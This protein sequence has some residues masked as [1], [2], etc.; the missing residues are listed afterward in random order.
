M[1]TEKKPS[2]GIMGAGKIG[3]SVA[4]KLL[5][6]GYPVIGLAREPLD[7]L[8]A[9]G[10]RVASS[11]AELAAQSEIVVECLGS[12]SGFEAVV[13]G[14][15]G[16]LTQAKPGQIIIAL[17]SDSLQFKRDQAENLAR[18]GIGHLDATVSG[19][20]TKID[21]GKAII[22]IGGDEELVSQCQ[23]VL[24]SITPTWHHVGDHG[25]ATKLKFVNNTLSFV[26]NLAAAEALALSVKLGLDPNKVVELLKN[27][28]GSSPALILR[29]PKMAT[30]QYEPVTGDMHGALIV[31]D[32]ILALAHEQDADLP[33][34]TKAGE[35]Y[36]R[37]VAEGRGDQ[38]VAQ[39]F[40]LVL[41]HSTSVATS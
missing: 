16:F 2:I 19:G 3:L 32:A 21:E 15:D 39:L 38:D 26:H 12:Q 9:A 23:S 4:K 10:G 25:S 27:G 28:T 14:T 18:H 6:A 37:A 11:G 17:S 8:V 36:R 34:L 30:R 41:D 20:P 7:A 5:A 24:D 29:G 33:L 35:Y 31:L 13:H 40:E 1:D 22:F